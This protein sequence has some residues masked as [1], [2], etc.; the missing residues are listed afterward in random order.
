MLNVDDDTDQLQLSASKQ[1]SSQ[2]ISPDWDDD[3]DIAF[4]LLTVKDIKLTYSTISK[5]VLEMVQ[6]EADYFADD[7]NSIDSS[8]TLFPQVP[9][10]K[11]NIGS[12]TP[13]V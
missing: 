5:T 4:K 7:D 3:S 8:M 12:G 13:N 6:S 10:E 11:Q 1:R 2:V 9:E